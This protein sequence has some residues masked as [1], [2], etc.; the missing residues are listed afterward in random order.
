[1]TTKV[2]EIKVSY[3]ERIA[4]SFWQKISRSRDA[5]EVLF[6]H[7]D[8][9]TIGL[10]EAFKV[11]LLNNSNKVKGIYQLSTGGITGTMVDVRLLVGVALKTASVACIICHSHPSGKLEPSQPDR[12]L[13]DKIKKAGELLDIKVL[14]H[15]ILVPNGDYYSFADN[16]LI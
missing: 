3:K 2:N 5:A 10:Q 9:D 6:E 16:G 11:L 14:D 8:K 15:I 12:D 1:M 13:T 7:W 4:A